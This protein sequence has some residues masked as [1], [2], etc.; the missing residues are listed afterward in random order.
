MLLF[1]L[2][3]GQIASKTSIPVAPGMKAFA[4][5]DNHPFLQR[6][7]P[8]SPLLVSVFHILLCRGK[9]KQQEA[10]QSSCTRTW[11][12]KKWCA[13]CLVTRGRQLYGRML[14]RAPSLQTLAVALEAERKSQQ[15]QQFLKKKQNLKVLR[16][17]GMS[18]REMMLIQA[19]SLVVVIRM[20]LKEPENGGIDE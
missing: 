17:T 5:P 14:L 4:R 2:T 18:C 12:D 20:P 1:S 3:Q 11:K 10:L 16:Y 19:F 13:L 15:Q 6:I 7:A 8:T 9:A